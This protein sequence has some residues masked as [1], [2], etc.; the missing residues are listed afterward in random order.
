MALLA[1]KLSFGNHDVF[2]LKRTNAQCSY[3]SKT[4]YFIAAFLKLQS[5]LLDGRLN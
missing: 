3:F 5:K 4:L 2:S 1:T